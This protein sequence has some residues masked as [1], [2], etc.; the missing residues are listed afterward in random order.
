MTSAA[1]ASVGVVWPAAALGAYTLASG[2]NREAMAR[3]G[4]G[5]RAVDAV[6]RRLV[7]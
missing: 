2:R 5:L 1:T 4:E 3:F 7:G 6:S